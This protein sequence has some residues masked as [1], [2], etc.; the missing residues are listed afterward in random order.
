MDSFT[1]AVIVGDLVILGVILALILGD[2]PGPVRVSN[3]P[4]A[5]RPVGKRP[6]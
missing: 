1:V 4:P 6:A 3:E 2:K 5:P